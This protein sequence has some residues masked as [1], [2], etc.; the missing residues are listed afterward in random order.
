M[1]IKIKRRKEFL[2]WSQKRKE[3]V[4]SAMERKK[5]KKELMQWKEKRKEKAMGA[6]KRKK[7]GNK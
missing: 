2:R 6:M 7:K 5:R 1:K 4:I 3:K